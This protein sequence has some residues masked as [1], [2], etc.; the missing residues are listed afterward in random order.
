MSYYVVQYRTN[1]DDLAGIDL[2]DADENMVVGSVTR[3]ECWL[4]CAP[5]IIDTLDRAQEFLKSYGGGPD[6]RIISVL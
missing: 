1:L 6:Y 4:D 3:G 2:P 5:R